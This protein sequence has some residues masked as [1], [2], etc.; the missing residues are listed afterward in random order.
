MLISNYGVLGKDQKGNVISPPTDVC[1][2]VDPAGLNYIRNGPAGAGG[3]VG[4]IYRW[5]GIER[6]S[7]F[8]DDV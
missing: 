5:L 8:P 4:A 3:A 1:V 2:I 6:E 7:A